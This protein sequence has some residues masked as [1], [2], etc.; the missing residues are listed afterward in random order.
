MRKNNFATFGLTEK[1]IFRYSSSYNK[2]NRAKDTH[3]YIDTHQYFGVVFH[4]VRFECKMEEQ[5]SV[6]NIENSG[7]GVENQRICLIGDLNSD[8]KTI[9]AAKTF[10]V[11]I[12]YSDTGI[13]LICDTEWTTY[14]VMSRFDGEAY[15]KIRKSRHRIYGPT[16]L[17]QIA[18]SNSGLTYV[19]RPIYNFA[20]KGVITCITG[21]RKKDELTHLVDLIH[22]MGGSIRK[23]LNTRV[24]HLICNQSTGEKYQY[25]MTFR[26]IVIRSNW[27]HKA[28]ERRSEVDFFA[29]NP[30]FSDVHKLRPFDGQKICFYGFSPEEHQ[31]MVDVLKSNGGSYLII[32]NNMNKLIIRQVAYRQCTRLARIW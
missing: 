21:I 18:Q 29:V 23:D 26:L 14:F 5:P 16:A 7:G 9:E 2:K 8:E 30:E 31:E 6:L 20:M 27:V 17:Q 3:T 22:A 28:W 32:C 15:N 11:P 25:A 1:Y 24:T 13:E 19:N 12:L 4:L 10:S